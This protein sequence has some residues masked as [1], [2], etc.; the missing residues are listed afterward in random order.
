[1]CGR[2]TLILEPEAIQNELHLGDFPAEFQPRYNIAPSQPIAVVTDPQKRNVQLFRWGLIPAWA[3]DPGIG[4]RLINA[5][6]E[7]LAEKPAFRT[8][9]ARRR[10]LILAD[11][12]YEW[13]RPDGKS[14]SKS[15]AVPYLF[16]LASGKPFAFAGL[17][18]TWHS[19]AG[20]TISTCTII[21]TSAN[22][23]VGQFHERMPVILDEQKLWD[24]LDPQT[25]PGDLANL[26]KPYPADRMASHPVSQL[27]NNPATD[28]RE[29]ITPLVDQD[30]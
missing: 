24:W 20:N 18:D 23:H 26:L 22:E 17:W 2:F 14:K 29:C 15:P 6:A 3:K 25:S 30:Q 19:P 12:F 5:R 8:A 1:M 7:T 10:C 28:T 27:V 21:T 16:R 11:G 9:L 13:F 4:N